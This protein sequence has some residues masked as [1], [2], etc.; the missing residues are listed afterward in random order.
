[1]L[2]TAETTTMKA[3]CVAHVFVTINNQHSTHLQWVQVV[4]AEWNTGG[5]Y[6]ANIK[7]ELLSKGFS[8]FSRAAGLR[9]LGLPPD[10]V[11]LQASICRVAC[12]SRAKF[13]HRQQR[14]SICINGIT[15]ISMHYSAKSDCT[16]KL[17][18]LIR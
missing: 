14:L 4:T 10:Y 3:T 6:D 5:R 16:A 9:Y 2:P 13:C 8:D 17:Q 12:K 15:L 18:N 1:M 11:S 7:L